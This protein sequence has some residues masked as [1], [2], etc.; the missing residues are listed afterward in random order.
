MAAVCYSILLS[1]GAS[2]CC[3]IIQDINRK[4][5]IYCEGFGPFSRGSKGKYLLDGENNTGLAF[6]QISAGGFHTCVLHRAGSVECFGANFSGQLDIPNHK[7]LSISSGYLHTCGVTSDHEIACWGKSTFGQSTAP[8]GNFIEVGSGT[9]CV[10]QMWRAGSD[11][12]HKLSG[13][14][15]TCAIEKGGAA[16]HCFGRNDYGQAD[17]PTMSAERAASESVALPGSLPHD[18][19]AAPASM[20][21]AG[22]HHSCAVWQATPAPAEGALPPASIRCWGDDRW[23]QANPPGPEALR[24]AERAAALACGAFHT[25]ALL[26]PMGAPAGRPVC[27][28]RGTAARVPERWADEPFVSLTAGCP[29]HPLAPSLPCALRPPSPCATHPH[30]WE[31]RSIPA[32]PPPTQHLPPPW[33]CAPPRLDHAQRTCL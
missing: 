2:Q 22:A 14:G 31:P 21:C 24:P 17:A 32:C 16:I 30:R 9:I 3:V 12:D 29:P 7:Y 19:P 25:C 20:V 13:D 26:G 33:R 23:G 4:H 6:Q 5:Y 11:N 1:C 18:P 28:G 8:N 10:L 27:W 15:H